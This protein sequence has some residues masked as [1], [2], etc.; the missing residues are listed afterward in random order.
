MGSTLPWGHK[1]LSQNEPASTDEKYQVPC[2]GC[3]P[4]TAAPRPRRICLF[5]E[6]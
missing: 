6:D 2:K 4:H 5:T 3:A 1:P